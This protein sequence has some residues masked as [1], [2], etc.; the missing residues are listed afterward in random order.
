MLRNDDILYKLAQGH[1][2]D[3]EG[4]LVKKIDFKGRVKYNT[5]TP[6]V[7]KVGKTMFCHPSTFKS[8]PFATVIAQHSWL[9]GNSLD[10]DWDSVVIGHTH[11]GGKIIHNGKMLIEQGCLTGVMDYQKQGTLYS[12]QSVQGY[13]VI[14]QDAAGN[15]D[16][17]KSNFIYCSTLSSL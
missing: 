15:T 16:F 11:K 14:W 13:A 5:K 8:G 7:A 17:N 1:V 4:N 12:N 9:L 3:K 6:W 2:Y 10:K